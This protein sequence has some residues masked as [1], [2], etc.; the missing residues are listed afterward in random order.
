[1]P[2]ARVAEFLLDPALTFLNHGSFGACPRVVLDAQLAYRE[3]LERDPVRFLAGDLE[4][5]LDVARQSAAAF[6]DAAPEDFVFVRNA[7]SAVNTV[8]ASFPFRA[9]DELLV[10]D[11][12]YAA[13]RNAAEYWAARA[14]ARVVEA[15]L[16][17]PLSDADA[18]LDAIRRVLTPRTRFALVDH[19]T[20]PS[21]L[22]LPIERIVAELRDRGVTVLVD[23]AHA[24]GM[25]P[26]SVRAVG[27]DYYTGNFHK[28]CCAPKGAAFLATTP[29]RR[30]TLRPLVVSHGATADRPERP[31]AWLE[32]DWVGTEDPTAYLTVPHALDFIRTALPG[33][34]AALYQQNRTLVLE[35]RAL[36]GER[37]GAVPS[38]PSDFVGS[39]A[40]VTLPAAGL[41]A[42]AALSR[43]LL[44]E[45]RIEVPVFTVNGSRDCAFRVSAHL[46]NALED[47]QH[48]AS[49]LELIVR[50][51]AN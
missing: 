50:S 39:M 24:P 20:S 38:A 3:R 19:V 45:H 12:G 5:L 26:L 49:A 46:Y 16:P 15:C 42:P 8:L 23:G 35:A 22:V 40:T 6:V 2:N 27:A 28:W 21:A 31:R 1:M 41:P 7:T 14:S 17:W 43:R 18:A 37:L 36:L 29:A 47:Y 44:E 32:F 33:G 51:P 25:L 10:T 34:L 11:H 48:F 4:G 30:G 9:G 13:C